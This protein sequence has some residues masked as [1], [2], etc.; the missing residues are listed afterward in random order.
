MFLLKFFLRSSSRREREANRSEGKNV[1]RKVQKSETLRDCWVKW[2]SEWTKSHDNISRLVGS[3][4]LSAA[5]FADFYFLSVLSFILLLLH[6]YATVCAFS[7]TSFVRPQM[8]RTFS[9]LFYY[10]IIKQNTFEW[11][12][13]PVWFS[14]SPGATRFGTSA[15]K[16]NS[17]GIR[18][19]TGR[20]C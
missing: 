16:N 7:F 12:L 4:A 3:P 8:M 14:P 6:T 15:Q 18:V 5:F 1:E 13:I 11:C 17:E 9:N 19:A 2:L 10:N 20:T